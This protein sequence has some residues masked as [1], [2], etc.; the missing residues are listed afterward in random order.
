MQAFPISEDYE[1][2]STSFF[3]KAVKSRFQE[4]VITK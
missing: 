4:E 2:E 1:R 3:A